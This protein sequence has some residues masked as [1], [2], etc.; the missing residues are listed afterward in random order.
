MALRGFQYLID[1]YGERYTVPK[2]SAV[3]DEVAGLLS[4]AV[5][6]QAISNLEL[7][8]G[9]IAIY[10]GPEPDYGM[11]LKSK[12]K[13]S[14]QNV[15]VDGIVGAIAYRFQNE[16]EVRKFKYDLDIPDVDILSCIGTFSGEYTLYDRLAKYT[17]GRNQ[18]PITK[19]SGGGK[20]ILDF[21]KI[22]A[23]IQKYMKDFTVNVEGKKLIGTE[24]DEDILLH[25]NQ[26]ISTQTSEQGITYNIEKSGDLPSD[27]DQRRF[28]LDSIITDMDIKIISGEIQDYSIDEYSNKTIIRLYFKVLED[29]S[30]KFEVSSLDN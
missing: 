27:P 9:D 24:Y 17:Y 15:D 28:M 10:V 7:K 3:Q 23:E 8:N 29:Y 6:K 13:S 22:R 25:G 1:N 21:Y 5:R 26:I 19:N 14:L 30:E 4:Q 2:D 20:I 16:L 11:A 12:I 18:R